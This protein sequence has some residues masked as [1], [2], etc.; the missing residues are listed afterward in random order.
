MMLLKIESGP[1]ERQPQ[2]ERPRTPGAWGA[3]QLMLRGHPYHRDQLEKQCIMGPSCSAEWYPRSLEQLVSRAPPPVRR[4]VLRHTWMLGTPAEAASTKRPQGK[5][6]REGLLDTSRVTI[7]R[8]RD[9]Q[10]ATRLLHLRGCAS[11]RLVRCA[12]SFAALRKVQPTPAGNRAHGDA[13]LAGSKPGGL[14]TLRGNAQPR[15]VSRNW[16]VAA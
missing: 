7:W 2:E 9:N 6:G 15:A 3:A 12:E 16:L 10:Q 13:S 4:P 8:A 14:A 5:P 1:A 11:R